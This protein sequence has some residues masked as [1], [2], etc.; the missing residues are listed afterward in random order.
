M[1]KFKIFLPLFYIILI[2]SASKAL[3]Q[4]AVNM[5]SQPN[6][7]YKETFADIAN[8]VFNA[9]PAN[10]T[11]SSGIGAA[12]WKGCD[13][14]TTGTIP[15]A[16]KLTVASN[17][18]QTPSGTNA[19]SGIYKG[20]QN[21]QLISTGTTDNSTSVAIDF[22][23]DFT[24]LN[25]G[26]LS[27]DWAEV[28]NFTGN[29][30]GSI[31]VYCSVDGTNFT[32]LTTASVLNV[33]N[34]VATSGS[35][36]FSALPA[37]FNNSSSARLRF[38]YSNGTGGTSGARPKISINNVQ[39]TAIPPVACTAPTSQPT[40][41][42]VT[43]TAFSTVQAA[44]TPASSSP[45]G[46]L[47][48]ASVN[49]ALSSSPVNEKNYAIGDNLGDGTVVATTTASS[50]TALSLNA[51]T[52]YNFFIFSM[53]HL[54]S[55]GPLYNTS[56][57][58]QGTATT[59]TGSEPCTA[60]LAQPTQLLFSGITSSAVYGS[61]TNALADNYLVIRSTS[62]T[63]NSLPVNGTTYKA[64]TT[65]GNGTVVTLTPGNTFTSSGLA[66]GTTYYY[67]IFSANNLNCTGS[68]VYNTVTPLTKQVTTLAVTTCTNP[69]TPATSLQL[70]AD[71]KMITGF[72]K[73][74][75]TAD[76]YLVL[77]SKNS[78]LSSTPVD[79]TNYTVGSTIGNATVLAN[80]KATSF[81]A[82]NL[83]VGTAY[84]F[85][86]IPQNKACSGT[87]KYLTTNI[88]KGNITT[89]LS[90]LTNT[91]FGN[92]HA[93]S[94][95]SDGNKDSTTF[96]PADNYNYAKN[97]MC[98]DYLGIS[99][100]NHAG[101][102]MNISNWQ[103]GL[104]QAS[105]ATT[106]NFLALYGMEW[107]IISGG[108][109]VLVY[110]S[111]QLLGW[112][113]NNYNLYVPKN[114]YIGTQSTTGTTGLFATINSLGNNVVALLAHPSNSDFNNL[115]NIPFNATADSAIVG[116]AISSGPAFSTNTTYTDPSALSYYSYY[117]TLLADGY[118][119]GPSMDH[120]NHYT[121][122][123]R[124][125]TTRLAINA[126]NLTT[127]SFL[128]ALKSRNFYAT[129][130]CDTRATLTL[131]NEPM[132]SIISGNTPPAISVYALDPTNSGSI[133]KINI[134]YGIPGSGVSAVLLDSI[135][136]YSFNFTD[137]NIPNNTTAYYF[138]EIII[139][140]AKTITSPIWYTY[141]NGALPVSLLDFKALVTPD[142][143]V[144]I[145][146]A[147]ATE[148]NNGVF[149]IEKSIDGVHYAHLSS[150]KGND[151]SALR[152]YKVIDNSPSNGI[153]YYRLVQRDQNGKTSYSAIASVNI[154]E[155]AINFISINTNPVREKLSLN[156]N[157]KTQLT[158][159]F[160]ISDM[161]GRILN[162]SAALLNKGSQQYTLNTSQLLSGTYAVMVTFGESKVTKLFIKQ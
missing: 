49:A 21:I 59:L 45:Q 147:T 137:V 92:L 27:F 117:K 105:A 13:I 81:I 155:A 89:K 44:F 2:S 142:K 31:R 131:N 71:S 149:E 9:S 74:S 6:N 43:N 78:T 121:T 29:R 68:I 41:F 32:E 160:F 126:S 4:V 148:T 144:E 12:A 114:D 120:D 157:S 107:G 52:T 162:K 124:T 146:W 112:E 119:V 34:N 77:Y 136:G 143:L 22:F 159:N 28:R 93:H 35:I 86:I 116:A 62:S 108:G 26:T 139:G 153:N 141:N 85:Y 66:S 46:Y 99:E 67:F 111:D 100:H 152:N 38:Y 150:I 10:G 110:G 16:T 76:S 140:G 132:G 145:K 158:A 118:H 39:V 51:N 70:K 61:F 122:F 87:V 30:T 129:E 73:A 48:V 11:F 95:Y 96:T 8:W 64:N 97:S 55:G 91:Y 83:S 109:H 138:A 130:D 103:P 161:S 58:L 154:A 42:T 23:M 25:A 82:A 53:N 56:S 7:T 113:S 37:I 125:A 14:N 123:G 18:F 101:A 36:S 98:L 17:S 134:M 104:A 72:F 60:P 156:I 79:G 19:F 127:P 94:S 135:T 80:G 88:L 90:P 1:S 3:G 65:I 5:A 54:C 63:L 75:T 133:P 50:F 69:T 84:Y 24:G 15:S 47:V 102:G 57:P 115:A 128:S 151:G 40:N 20:T 33:V 106:A